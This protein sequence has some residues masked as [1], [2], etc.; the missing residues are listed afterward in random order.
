MRT[1]PLSLYLVMLTALCLCNTAQAATLEIFHPWVREAPPSSRV[2]AAYMTVKNPGDTAIS[3]EGI[4]S[5]DFESAEVHR[6]VVHEGMARMLHIK[7]LEIPAKGTVRLEPGG[8]H[9]M[10]FNPNRSLATGDSVTLTLHLGNG[11]CLTLDMPVIRQA[12]DDRAPRH[13]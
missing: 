13:H 11:I 1:T 8:L 7:Q 9:L 12:A 4:S 10:L 6:T 5:P 2:L 3:I